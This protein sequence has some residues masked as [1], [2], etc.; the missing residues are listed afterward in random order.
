MDCSK[1][2]KSNKVTNISKTDACT[3]PRAVMVMNFNAKATSAAVKWS[4][5]SKYFTSVTK[6]QFVVTITLINCRNWHSVCIKSWWHI[7]EFLYVEK[8]SCKVVFWY[9]LLFHCLFK[10]HFVLI[11]R[12]IFNIWLWFFLICFREL[13]VKW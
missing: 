5:G 9:L 11:A 6:T 1:K 12:I 8:F 2:E 4:W 13:G 10:F 7:F 3:H